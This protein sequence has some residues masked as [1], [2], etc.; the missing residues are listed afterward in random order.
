MNNNI[1]KEKKLFGKIKKTNFDVYVNRQLSFSLM[2][3]KFGSLEV[4]SEFSPS[5]LGLNSPRRLTSEGVLQYF[6]KLMDQR[7]FRYVWA[8]RIMNLR[9]ILKKA[10]EPA[11]LTL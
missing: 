9:H 1:R 4:N 7:V 10:A 11:E 6:W 8:K 3:S 2:S 5:L